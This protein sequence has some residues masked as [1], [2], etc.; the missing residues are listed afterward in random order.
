YC[1]AA[2]GRATGGI[3]HSMRV[4]HGAAGARVAAARETERF[5]DG[6]AADRSAGIEN[7]G[8][9]GRVDIGDIAF[10]RRG[11]VHHRHAGKTYI[12]FKRD[13]LAPEL[14]RGGALDLGLDVPGTM[15]VLLRQRTS[16]GQAWIG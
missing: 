15:P 8:H 7:A 6:C 10:H 1:T 14:A 4:V 13:F 16:A 3:T 11:A 2:R 9:D 5:R 12:V